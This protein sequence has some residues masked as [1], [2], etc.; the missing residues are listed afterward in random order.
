MVTGSIPVETLFFF[1]SRFYARDDAAGGTRGGATGRATIEVNFTTQVLTHPDSSTPRTLALRP[2]Q[3]AIRDTQSTPAIIITSRPHVPL[4]AERPRRLGGE[5]VGERRRWRARGP[6]P[7]PPPALG[8]A[9]VQDHHACPV[10]ARV[11]VDER[12]HRARG[13]RSRTSRRRRDPPRHRR[14]ATA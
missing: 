14:A 8:D 11:L 5:A 3:A 6:G 13:L 10:L 9:P 1:G 7:V 4:L 2:E 12:H